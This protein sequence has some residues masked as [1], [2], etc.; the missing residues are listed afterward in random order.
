LSDYQAPIQP[1]MADIAVR[2]ARSLKLEFSGVDLLQTPSGQIF[3]LEANFPCYF[4]QAQLVAGID[5]S[6]MMIDHLLEKA[7][8]RSSVDAGSHVRTLSI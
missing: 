5:I 8:K 2:A 1:E 6:G 4:P 7:R 3:A